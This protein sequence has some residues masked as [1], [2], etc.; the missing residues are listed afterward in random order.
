MSEC[1]PE[2]NGGAAEIPVPDG[3]LSRD[4]MRHTISTSHTTVQPPPLR[5]LFPLV[6]QIDWALVQSHLIQLA[7]T[8]SGAGKSVK[9]LVFG[10][11]GMGT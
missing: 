7:G 10:F 6:A 11:I 1:I 9:I 3:I 4:S 2:A 8:W 5:S